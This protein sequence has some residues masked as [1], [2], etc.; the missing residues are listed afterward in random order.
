MYLLGTFM[1]RNKKSDIQWLEF[2]VLQE[3]AKV[4]HGVFLRQ[5]GV[6]QAPF[7]SLNLS[8][9]VGDRLEDVQKN[10]NIVASFFGQE[11]LASCK[12]FHSDLV[13]EHTIT[14]QQTN[15]LCDGVVCNTPQIALAVT[16]A[17]CQ[18]ALFY[19]PIQHAIACI[20][21]GWRGSVK[22]IYRN[23]IQQMKGRYGTNPADVIVCIS[24]SLGPESAE[25]V[26]YKTEL[27]EEFWQFQMKPTYFDFWEISKY[28][29]K[30]E[31]ILPEH[32][33]VAEI[34]T[35]ANPHDYFSY[36]RDK[37]TGRHASVIM[38]L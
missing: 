19:D 3:F 18:A 26:N 27:P 11:N 14:T 29:L 24:P 36:R 13:Q 20:H 30:L 6:S 23:T 28:Q 22:N 5:G 38:L 21:S 8:Y 7:H 37:T 33:H 2:E 15:L 12:A 31:G 17:D 35:V 1:R 10:R 25:F 34:D 16:H 32:I 9:S 4:K